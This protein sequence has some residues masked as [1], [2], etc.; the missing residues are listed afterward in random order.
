MF[1]EA[2]Q[3]CLGNIYALFAIPGLALA[4]GAFAFGFQAGTLEAGWGARWVPERIVEAC[5]QPAHTIEQVPLIGMWVRL[6]NDMGYEF[7][8]GPQTTR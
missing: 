4:L 8:D 5:C 3:R 7:A 6:A 1:T 2:T